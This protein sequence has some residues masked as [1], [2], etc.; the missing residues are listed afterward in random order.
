MGEITE[1]TKVIK[2][3][4]FYKC[5]KVDGL[6]LCGYCLE[7]DVTELKACPVCG[8]RVIS[9]VTYIES[10]KGGEKNMD[11]PMPLAQ[12]PSDKPNIALGK[13]FP[14]AMRD[15]IDGK[16]VT[17]LEWKNNKIYG[18]LDTGILTLVKEDGKKYK[19]IVSDGDMTAT[20]WIALP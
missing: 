5:P 13:D 15:V 16:H 19:W 18:V 10:E 12:S 7:G 14:D 20:D 9:R 6:Y 4:K 11:N 3:F 2:D 8:S 1:I 17:R